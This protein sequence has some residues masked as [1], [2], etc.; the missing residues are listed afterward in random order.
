MTEIRGKQKVEE[1]GK[2]YRKKMSE[3]DKQ[4][5][6]EYLKECNKNQSSNV[7][8]KYKKTISWKVLK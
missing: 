8:K 7:L 2:Q 5:K 4:K 6:K 1:Y 3:E